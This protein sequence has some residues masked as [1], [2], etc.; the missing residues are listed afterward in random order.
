M[1]RFPYVGSGYLFLIH[2]GEILLQRRANTGFEDGNYGV[3]AGHLDGNETARE[4]TARE[5]REEIGITLAPNDLTLAHFMHR[6]GANDERFDIFWH[7]ERYAGE[8][9]NMEPNKCDDLS[10]F[11]LDALPDNMMTMYALLSQTGKKV[12]RTQSTVGKL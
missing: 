4:G 5:M 6:K 7:T 9:T 2:D 11:P 10:W 12:F 3:P 8:I 1:N